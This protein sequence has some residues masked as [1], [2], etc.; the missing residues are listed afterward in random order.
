MTIAQTSSIQGT[1]VGFVLMAAMLWGTT[2]TAQS[3]A[4]AGFDPLIIGTCRLAIG[5]AALLLLA[6]W[7]KEINRLSQWPWAKILMGALLTGTYQVSFFVGV[8]RTGVAVGTIVAIGSSPMAAGILAA[9]FS[10]EKP[11]KRWALATI[12]AVFGCS[13]LMLSGQGGNVRID[14]LGVFLALVAGSAYASYTL[15]IKDLLQEYSPNAVTAVVI[16]VSAILL[17][18]LFFLRPVAWLMQPESMLVVLHLGLISMALAYWFFVRGLQIISVPVAVTLSLA[19]PMTAGILGVLVVGER[20]SFGA[21]CGL[22][23]ILSGLFILTV[24]VNL[25]KL[26]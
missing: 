5:G 1:G 22:G 9:L 24:K 20:L 19:E 2:G 15:V 11:G 7:R 23:L 18:P 21:W 13:L 12:V 10:R 26:K 14:P 6:L 25:T 3:F 4:P 16:S 17:S 8:A